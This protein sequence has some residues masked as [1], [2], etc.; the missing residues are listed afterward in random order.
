LCEAGI[1]F[2]DL[3]SSTHCS[4]LSPPTVEEEELQRRGDSLRLKTLQGDYDQILATPP[5]TVPVPQVIS[6]KLKIGG[7]G[8]QSDEEG[9]ESVEKGSG[10]QEHHYGL[11]SHHEKPAWLRTSVNSAEAKEMECVSDRPT[12]SQAIKG[13]EWES[14][15]K[16]ATEEEFD[17]LEERGTG[18]EV[19]R[20]Q[21]P[22]GAMIYPTKMVYVKKRNASNE[23]LN[24]LQ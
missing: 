14:L 13:P 1:L 19:S 22:P 8:S 4:S 18:E 17:N 15:W 2:S 16:R 7:E 11:R 21:I 5:I 6:P 3:D 20:D 12:L 24:F 23:F 10:G 9:S